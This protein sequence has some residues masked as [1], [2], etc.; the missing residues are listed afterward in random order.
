MRNDI[1][2]D[3]LT[4][5]GA[6][7]RVPEQRRR[8]RPINSLQAE[9]LENRLLLSA[10]TIVFAVAPQN[11]TAGVA[12]AQV[13]VDIDNSSSVPDPSAHGIVTLTV[14]GPG[15][16]NT[17]RRTFT[18]SAVNGV[19]EFQNDLVLDIA[20][21]YTLT[22]S[23]SRLQNT[24]STGFFITPD[25]GDAEH[26]AFLNFPSKGTAG[27]PLS[28]F[29]VGI[30]DR[31]GNLDTTTTHDGD[32][33]VLPSLTGPGGFD[34]NSQ[35]NAHVANGIAIFNNVILDTAGAYKMTADDA[36]NSDISDGTSSTVT[37]GAGQAAAL[38]FQQ[39]DNTLTGTAGK[40]MTSF[41]VLVE[42]A[43]GNLV[44]TDNSTIQL[45]NITTPPQGYVPASG[46]KAQAHNGIAKFTPTF[47]TATQYYDSD[48]N[49]NDVPYVLRASDAADGIPTNNAGNNNQ[50]IEINADKAAKLVFGQLPAS[51]ST[52]SGNPVIFN[53]Y[54][55]D[56]YGNVLTN[57]NSTVVQVLIATPHGSN[58][59][60]TTTATTGYSMQVA[61]G[62]AHFG[63]ALDVYFDNSGTYTLSATDSTSRSVTKAL[64]GSISIT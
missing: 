9:V 21:T 62:Q 53:V 43:Y 15:P 41:N 37:I 8:R 29:K 13:E 1:W 55:E 24:V 14:N 22:A 30:E 23:Y 7:F 25:T 45:T 31:F 19:A 38:I 46:L 40:A 36:D 20:G 56:R 61:N 57:D 18:T 58:F 16:F 4:R 63:S 33:I 17:G 26:L 64:S 2:R 34:A 27:M 6:F 11:A 50:V 39:G 10:D 32:N 54:V 60:G 52:G 59:N 49:F 3:W 47:T 48:S 42:D 5:N 44:K 51:G 35:P 28:T 12:Q